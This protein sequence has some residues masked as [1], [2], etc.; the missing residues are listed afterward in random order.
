MDQLEKQVKNLAPYYPDRSLE[1]DMHDAKNAVI[2]LGL[3]IAGLSF[4]Y[5][6]VDEIMVVGGSFMA[7][8]NSRATARYVSY[9]IRNAYNSLRKKKD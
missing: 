7:G 8:W 3:I 6:M 2:G 9:S 4:D 5:G 1:K